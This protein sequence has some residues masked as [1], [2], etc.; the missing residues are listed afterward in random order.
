MP[1]EA[2]LPE[3]RPVVGPAHSATSDTPD[4]VL[5]RPAISAS[6]QTGGD[7]PA[8]PPAPDTT[9]P[10]PEPA[11][12]EPEPAPAEPAEP[13]EPEPA[14]AE[15]AEPEPAAVA[16]RKDSGVGK[17]LNKL[18]QDLAAANARA[19]E[20]ARVNDQLLAQRVTPPE[21]VTPVVEAKPDLK[22]V[23]PKRGDFETPD[24]YDAAMLTHLDERD[25]WTLRQA[26]ARTE[27]KLRADK[28]IADQQANNA[29]VSQDY[30]AVQEA[31]DAR[32]VKATE[33]YADFNE[34]AFANDVP[35]SPSMGVLIMN[36]DAGPDLM[37]HLA[38]HK[39]EAARIANLVIPGQFFPEGHE[40]AGMPV[41][42]VA[43]QAREMGK[44]EGRLAAAV[45]RE[46]APPAPVR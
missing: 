6:G 15:P 4:F 5:S 2:P 27:A 33:K 28:A 26:D 12:A 31:H 43:L 37:Y 34:V 45:S 14:P 22:P 11:P 36:S 23:P 21:P 8:D 46:T 30:A 39:D 10:A 19:A 44:L 13:S 9:E 3:T 18:E 29:R 20:L 41:P 1:P 25:A 40:W 17:V 35:I 16:G 7:M 32:L 24:A 38:T 42:N